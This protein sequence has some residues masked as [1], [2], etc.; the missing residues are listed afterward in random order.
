MFILLITITYRFQAASTAASVASS[1]LPTPPSADSDSDEDLDLEN[2]YAELGLDDLESEP[3]DKSDSGPSDEA[4]LEPEFEPEDEE[5]KAER[6]RLAKEENAKK[7]A[8]LVARHANWENKLVDRIAKARKELRRNLVAS[9]KAA[10]AELKQ[11]PEI[12]K[13]IDSFVD[14]AEK[15]LKGAEKYLAQSVKDTKSGRTSEE[16]LATWARVVDKI[17]KRFAER[18][19][20]TEAVVNG[21]YEKVLNAELAEVG[22]TIYPHRT[23]LNLV[24]CCVGQ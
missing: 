11:S 12:Q 21:W 19:G 18:I 20:Q 3:A 5:A 14:D 2:L 10:A 15:Y 7:R 24:Y 9:R 16:K 1:I 23:N 17:E 13:E 6:L 22:S 4:Y 8:E